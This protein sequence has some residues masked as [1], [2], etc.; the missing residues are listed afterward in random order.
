MEELFILG[1]AFAFVLVF[2]WAARRLY[3]NRPFSFC[4]GEA[5]YTRHGDGRFT[6][7]TGATVADPEL[8]RRLADE[9][10]VVS[11]ADLSGRTGRYAWPGF[12]KDRERGTRRA[13]AAE[14]L[15]RFQ[16]RF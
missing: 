4:L 2:V 15:G 7:A 16:D 1:G 8:L 11:D 14:M 13:R 12:A 10:Y 3:F 9:W 5:I 6:T